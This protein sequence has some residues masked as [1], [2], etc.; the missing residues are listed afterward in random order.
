[1]FHQ[2]IGKEGIKGSLV[3]GAWV[4]YSALAKVGFVF[5][6]IVRIHITTLFGIHGVLL[7]WIDARQ[8]I[9]NKNLRI[10]VCRFL[11]KLAQGVRW[12][13]ACIP[14][15]AKR[16]DKGTTTGTLLDH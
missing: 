4:T 3:F 9:R 15:T 11:H 5:D 10:Q 1:M 16:G 13:R 7:V 6:Q 2:S 14:L 8:K 12:R